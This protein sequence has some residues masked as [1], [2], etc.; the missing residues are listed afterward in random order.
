MNTPDHDLPQSLS[1]LGSRNPLPRYSTT[2]WSREHTTL[3]FGFLFF[4]RGSGPTM[5]LFC[6]FTSS[7]SESPNNTANGADGGS[8]ASGRS[9][10]MGPPRSFPFLRAERYFSVSNY[11]LK[12]TLYLSFVLCSAGLEM[13]LGQKIMYAL[14]KF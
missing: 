3:H 5:E 9:P 7:K 4:P 6:T 1:H 8:A 2:F 11:V 10:V 13:A 12:R 14:K